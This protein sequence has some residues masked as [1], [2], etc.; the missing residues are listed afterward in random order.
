[1]WNI[2][3]AVLEICLQLLDRCFFRYYYRCY[4]KKSEKVLHRVLQWVSH[5]SFLDIEFWETKKSCFDHIQ[6]GYYSKL[7]GKL[8]FYCLPQI[9][10][11]WILFWVWKKGNLTSSLK[12]NFLFPFEH[13]IMLIAKKKNERG[14][15]IELHWVH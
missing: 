14:K 15:I 7:K 4:L 12:G 13:Y 9:Q 2:L 1:M 3:C 8:P 10:P 5:L 11:L 6:T